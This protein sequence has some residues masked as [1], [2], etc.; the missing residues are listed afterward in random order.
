MANCDL[1]SPKKWFGCW[2]NDLIDDTADAIGEK[3]MA[4][5]VEEFT[6]PSVDTSGSTLFM[7]A[8][9]NGAVLTDVYKATW[10]GASGTPTLMAFGLMLLYLALKMKGVNYIFGINSTTSERNRSLFIGALLIIFWWP[11][12][13]TGI[14]LVNGFTEA[15]IP[16]WDE[17]AG[18]IADNILVGS[19]ATILSVSVPPVLAAYFTILIGLILIN[20]ILFTAQNIIVYIYLLIG[21]ILVAVAYMGIP[22]LSPR[23]MGALKSYPLVVSLPLIPAIIARVFYV[24]F[25]DNTLGTI[26]SPV[27]PIVFFFLTAYLSWRWLKSSGFAGELATKGIKT[28]GG[29]LAAGATLGA[30][31]SAVTAAGVGS[32]VAKGRPSSAARSVA[33]EQIRQARY[34]SDED[35]IHANQTT[36]DTF[37]NTSDGTT[38]STE[39]ADD[40]TQERGGSKLGGLYT[41]SGSQSADSSRATES[42]TDVD[43]GRLGTDTDQTIGSLSKTNDTDESEESQ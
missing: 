8:Q 21:P 7:F 32:S 29:I 5:V 14:E 3:T 42:Y 23:A 9:P 28:G 37:S 39:S 12:G 22:G 24:L 20:G 4:S 27:I 26:L 35:S 1:S 17:L 43:E 25:V 41:E 31:A 16:S 33:L 11:L 15:L 34:G 40:Q 36:L 13:V 18:D 2:I 19:G 6:G 30:G 38:Q 10:L